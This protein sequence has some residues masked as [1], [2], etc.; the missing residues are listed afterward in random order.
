MS[1]IHH[2]DFNAY[3]WPLK[4]YTK[5]QIQQGNIFQKEKWESVQYSWMANTF[6]SSFTCVFKA[7]NG[8]LNLLANK[9]PMKFYLEN[10]L[11][12]VHI[13]INIV[14]TDIGILKDTQEHK[15]SSRWNVQTCT[16]SEVAV[17][18]RKIH[19]PM[20]VAL[21][22]KDYWYRSVYWT[23]CRLI[24]STLL[25]HNNVCY[26]STL[27]GCW[28]GLCKCKFHQDGLFFNRQFIFLIFWGFEGTQTSPFSA[29]R[30]LS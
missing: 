11:A 17:R 29:L 16:P 2:G 4:K 26:L 8:Q 9:T 1:K 24:E 25:S 20:S 5:R 27:L 22:L 21:W 12:S 18:I 6:H 23:D 3:K 7:A 30:G 19:W 28:W 13:N 10:D 14:A 15:I